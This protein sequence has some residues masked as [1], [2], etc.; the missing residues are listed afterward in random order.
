MENLTATA[1]IFVIYDGS[2]LVTIPL[3]SATVSVY[4]TT[5]TV[6]GGNAAST[7]SG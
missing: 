5:C 6:D 3:L 1:N 4:D 7:C 2:G